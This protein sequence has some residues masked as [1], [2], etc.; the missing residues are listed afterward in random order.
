LQKS[1]LRFASQSRRLAGFQRRPDQDNPSK[2]TRSALG[3]TSGAL[4]R[5]LAAWDFAAHRLSRTVSTGINLSSAVLPKSSLATRL[6]SRSFAASGFERGSVGSLWLTAMASFFGS[7]WPLPRSSKYRL[8]LNLQGLNMCV[9]PLDR[10]R[11]WSRSTMIHPRRRQATYW[12]ARLRLAWEVRR[13]LSQF[14]HHPDYRAP[15]PAV[16]LQRNR[17]TLYRRHKLGTPWILWPQRKL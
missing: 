7:Q 2:Q 13:A 3:R 8:C 17:Y 4:H 15:R 16:P 1:S 10:C 5:I 12:L 9:C 6:L 14:S 11:R